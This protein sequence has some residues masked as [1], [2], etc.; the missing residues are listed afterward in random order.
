MHFCRLWSHITAAPYSLKHTYAGCKGCFMLIIHICL[1][2]V[3][4]NYKEDMDWKN[5]GQL[6]AKL[7]HVD[8]N[9][10]QVR[11]GYTL[12]LYIVH[13]IFSDRFLFLLL[14]FGVYLIVFYTIS[15]NA[16]LFITLLF[17]RIQYETWDMGSIWSQPRVDIG[18]FRPQGMNYILVN[19][20]RVC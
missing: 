1:K 18:D 15:V 19:Y 4:C 11:R 2:L 14:Y 17:Q 12:F 6:I 9:L 16:N 10:I 8:K 3:C 7:C 5:G 13:D 20:G